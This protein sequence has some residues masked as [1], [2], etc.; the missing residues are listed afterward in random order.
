V[1]RHAKAASVGLRY[2]TGEGGRFVRSPLGVV[3]LITLCFVA[4][5]SFAAQAGAATIT[6]RPFLFSFK[7]AGGFDGV[8]RIAIDNVTGAVYVG[9]SGQQDGRGAV[10][11]FHPDGT[12]WNFS[13]SESP[14]LIG[15]PGGPFSN[16]LGVAV[17]NSGGPNQGHLFV[18]EYGGG[19]FSA[20][21]SS[22]EFLWIASPPNQSLD[23]AVDGA[24]HPWTAAANGEGVY[25]FANSGAPPA[26]LNTYPIG[27]TSELD[28]DQAGDLFLGREGGIQ[29]W[30]AG[31]FSSTIDP[32]ASDVYVD[33]S[34]P[35]GH[36]FTLERENDRFTEFDSSGAEIATMG[37][38]YL[39]DPVSIAYNASL[40]RVYVAQVGSNP[41]V[42]VFGPIQTGTVPDTSVEAPSGVGISSAHFSGTVN[43]QGVASE[44]H[45]EWRKAGASWAEAESSPP[46]SL[47]VDSSDHPVEFT[48]NSLRGGTTYEVRLVGVNN[49]NSLAGFSS[50]KGFTTTTAPAAPAVG[51][52]PPSAVTTT[53]ATI[54][55]TIN[56]QGDTADWRVQ[57]STDS[58]CSSGFVDQPQQQIHEGT[59][60]PVNV[61]FGLTNLL[62]SEAYC[63]RI[64]ATNS[65]GSTVSTAQQF[66]T[67]PVA[68]GEVQAMPAAP[69]LDTTA[70]L[71]ARVNPQGEDLT[72]HFEYSQD[73]GTTWIALADKV[74][75]SGSRTQKV[76]SE[77]ATGLDPNTTYSYRVTLGNPAGGGQG[78]PLN[79]TTRTIAAVTLP[80]RGYEL[81]NTPDKGN[82]S[83]E[84][85]TGEMG[86]EPISA[87]GEKV[88]WKVS[89]GAPQGSNGTGAIFLAERSPGGW[90]SRSLL[91]PAE[92]QIGGGS[93]LYTM[94]THTPDMS[95][96]LFTVARSTFLGSST[97]TTVVRLDD[98]QDQTVVRHYEET[99]QGNNVDTTTD[100]SHILRVDTSIHQIVDIGSGT[101]EVVSIMPGGS[102]SSCGLAPG[103]S[104][105]GQPQGAFGIPGAYLN[106]HPGY[107]LID[108]EDASIVYFE[109]HPDGDCKAQLGL[110]VRNRDDG[111]TTLIDPGLPVGNKDPAFVR[112]TPDGRYGYFITYSQLVSDDHNEDRDVYRWDNQTGQATCLTCVVADAAVGQGLNYTPA[113]QI[114]ISNDFSHIYFN[115][116]NQLEPGKGVAG[117]TSLYSLSNGTIHFVAAVRADLSGTGAQLPESGES[118]VFNGQADPN[119]T[120]DSVGL[121]GSEGK[122]CLEPLRINGIEEE[123]DC[124]E[125][126]RYQDSDQSVEC[127][128]CNRSGAT[129]Y[130]VGTPC[131]C[132]KDRFVVSADGDTV[133][134]AT[135]E[136]LVERDVNKTTDVYEWHNGTL[137]LI[138]DGVTQYQENAAA[139][140]P[141]AVSADGRDVFFRVQA[142]G[143][144]GHEQDL[145]SN[146]YD[147][148]VG[149]G[150]ER[151]V[152]PSHCSEE[153][154]QGPL[155]S[156]PGLRQSG[157]S[158]FTGQG[159]VA[160]QPKAS[161]CRKGK[162]RRHGRCV[163]RHHKRAS[164]TNRGGAK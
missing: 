21:D 124:T 51:I 46:Q 45:F 160:Q 146:L 152:P 8:H 123:T 32:L 148:R 60:T 100:G 6:D 144:T 15:R 34:S 13:A 128:S 66:T 105:T 54:S 108:T 9:E 164:K 31:S 59:A 22:G 138:T 73:G 43:P 85:L 145:L 163:G 151:P 143:L 103:E 40:S 23:V 157:S 104:F 76:I 139:P 130:A 86:D 89:G 2:R 134:F 16:E 136:R 153:S 98:R 121:A 80:R 53:S 114:V 84:T 83:L 19:R 78:D 57:L 92:G 44:W 39:G 149:G 47:S 58:S 18:S 117:Q 50:S 63:A 52:D 137:G 62:S 11:K 42:A 101:D 140:L 112:A 35:T 133:V 87:D 94:A 71:N 154:C 36:V 69:V 93:N 24:G 38:N 81:V 126:Y 5:L 79:F 77:E 109:A 70:R 127:L 65:A 10:Y 150:F 120:G 99:V 33:Q 159:N 55:G 162:V 14:V 75:T 106:W 28:L 88:L 7:A 82:Q 116:S 96:F 12:P 25:E 115:S 119:L 29:K 147:A 141:Q 102:P 113:E 74:D 20:F 27:N 56:P 37:G 118:L 41:S 90:H 122:K 26:L 17:D 61:S 135:K 158:S 4:S 156:P 129:R 67:S 48:S 68:P 1:R 64:S 155:Q 72:Y 95:N 97:D 110:Y 161:R 132:P 49:S 30:V 107:H 142:P 131:G 125:L 111:T 3:S 91:P